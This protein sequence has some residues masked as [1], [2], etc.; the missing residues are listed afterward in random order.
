MILYR[1][2]QRFWQKVSIATPDDCWEWQGSRRGDSY[3]Q[4]YIDGKHRATHRIAHY[5]ATR[6]WPQIGRAHV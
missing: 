5:L 2:T 3:G 1:D 6:T 4:L